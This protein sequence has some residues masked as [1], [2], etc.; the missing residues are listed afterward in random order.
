MLGENLL[1]TGKADAIHYRG[2]TRI[3]KNTWNSMLT[4]DQNRQFDTICEAFERA[5]SSGQTPAIEDR[6]AIVSDS[7]RSHLV[8]RL[9]ELDLQ[10][11]IR[12]GFTPDPDMYVRRWPDLDRRALDACARD[13]RH[14]ADELNV[15]SQ[16]AA[17]AKACSVEECL[18]R[19]QKSG[20]IQEPQ[21]N[22]IRTVAGEYTQAEALA[23]R[24]VQENVLTP[25]QAHVLIFEPNELLML[26]EYVLQEIV[27]SGGMGTVYRA[28]HRRMK[29]P[30]AIKVLRRDLAHSAE[31]AK[32]FLREV[33]VAARLHH[34][35]IVTAYDAGEQA[36]VSFL[37]SEF[38]E[39][40]NL[41]DLVR[42]YGPLSLPLA[43]DVVCQAARA[44]EYA[45]KQ[46][47]IHRDIKPS[48]LLLDDMGNVKLLDVGLAR[49]HQEETAAP[50]ESDLTMSGM[51]MGTFDYMSPEQALDARMADAQSDVYSLGCTL[52]FLITGRAPYARG[53]AIERLLAHREQP[54]PSL[55]DG[56][57]Q[58]SPA[59]DSVLSRLMAKKPEQ[60]IGS[61]AECLRE[62]EQL[63]AEGLPDITLSPRSAEDDC[64]TLP[65]TV[66]SPEKALL[67]ATC[68][69][70]ESCADVGQEVLPSTTVIGMMVDS[71]V[72]TA[73]PESVLESNPS[74]E[75]A[76][77]SGA[78]FSA[79]LSWV[80]IPGVAAMVVAGLLMRAQSPADRS[81]LKTEP[82][83]S[84]DALPPI[85][86]LTDFSED[87]AQAYQST[88]ATA[89]GVDTEET[90]AGI[91]FVFIPPGKFLYGEGDD[92]EVTQIDQEFWLSEVEVTVG[93]Y[94]AFVKA[95]GNFQTVAERTGNGWGKLG[96]RWVQAPEYSWK[97]LGENFVSEN[98]PACNITYP[99]A[100]AF[101]EWISSVSGRKIRLP[102]EQEWEYACRCGRRGA[103]SFGD[104]RNLL[105]QYA[106]VTQNSNDEVHPVR[107][108]LPNAW[109]L[110]DMQGN[111]TEW[112]FEP[113]AMGPDF[114]GTGPLRGGSFRSPIPQTRSNDSSRSSLLEPG[115]GAFRILMEKKL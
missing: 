9:V 4:H 112:C 48:N 76:R 21:L 30:A 63:K 103:W 94:A 89:V 10:C 73:I 56:T 43:V 102:R 82:A 92:A 42:E 78:S 86:S 72:T 14:T 16:K 74:V 85:E 47:V 50:A 26:G 51:I 22:H 3:V 61:M 12:S 29:R 91:V 58:M 69:T 31:L 62:L 33:E 109:G 24:L 39:G 52:F 83:A 88:W 19:L 45:H 68:V 38:V 2:Q 84:T 35:N 99:D 11:R 55:L 111:E 114:P 32:R 106:W 36:G 7:A 97:N 96:E 107:S 23:T 20:L 54:V 93:Q 100:I 6:L 44:L 77:R 64:R 27:G 37:V 90:A 87:A 46:G 71:T 49:I 8:Q 110:F 108:L 28:M 66:L 115:R 34:P 104:D 5:W 18:Q 81:S 79:I 60:R 113:N 70:T 75:H 95:V 53:T 80:F 67:P 41:A 101:C 105:E 98:S 59:L 17:R 15:T 25:W 57:P 1:T 65:E 13:W 40:Q